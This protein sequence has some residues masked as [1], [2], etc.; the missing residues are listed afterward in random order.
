VR[1]VT[2]PPDVLTVGE[3][4]RAAGLSPKAVRLYETKGLL[5]PTRR[6]DAGYPYLHR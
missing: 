3:A 1:R 4:A 6:T 2:M 5:L